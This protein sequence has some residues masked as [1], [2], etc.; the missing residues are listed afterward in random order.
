MS[1]SSAVGEIKVWV[2]EFGTEAAAFRVS[3]SKNAIVDDLKDAIALKM[4]LDVAAPVL[5][6]KIKKDAETTTNENEYEEVKKMR[7]LVTEISDKNPEDNPIYYSLPL[8]TNSNAIG[9]E[10]LG[11]ITKKQKV[12]NNVEIK[13]SPF[14]DSNNNK[15]NNSNNINDNNNDIND[16]DINNDNDIQ[17]L[18]LENVPDKLK[19][20]SNLLYSNLFIRPC[21]SEMYQEIKIDLQNLIIKKDRQPKFAI[22]GT[23][24]IGKSSFFL[25]FLYKYMEERKNG[26]KSFF[27]QTSQGSAVFYQHTEGDSFAYENVGC[28]DI[29]N[30]HGNKYPLFVDLTTPDPPFFYSGSVFIFTSFK[31]NRYKDIGNTGFIK[32]MPTWTELEMTDYFMSETFQSTFKP[33]AERQKEILDNCEIFGGAIRS[34]LLK[35]KSILDDAITKK[36]SNICDH[37]FKHGHGGSEDSISDILIHRNP[38]LDDDGKFMYDLNSSI[39]VYS[40]ASL[41]VFNKLLEKKRAS[42]INQ[43]K[44]K[45]NTGLSFGGDD[46]KEFEWLCFHIFKFSNKTFTAKPLLDTAGLNQ[47]NIH[48]PP[49]KYLV[50]DWKTKTNYLEENVLYL[51]T[52]SNLVSVDAFCVFELNKKNINWITNYYC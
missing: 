41:Y 11:G 12:S 45:F 33:N 16:N 19:I 4:K 9:G 39:L 31:E 40:F 47:F 32:I 2:K 34:V 10:V 29:D 51:P 38:Q 8:S 18:A 13:F 50:A 21:Y 30:L 28:D 37:F 46:G 24:G 14:V 35:Q 27:Y 44:Q 5:K 6:I 49:Q 23:A 15:G 17:F 22:V 7:T 26:D 1:T 48:F 36:G 52:I 42:L 43:A 25:Y 20:K 3:V